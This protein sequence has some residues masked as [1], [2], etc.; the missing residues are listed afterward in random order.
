M[1]H[2]LGSARCLCSPANVGFPWRRG[3]GLR[4]GAHALQDPF[5]SRDPTIQE[6]IAWI[7]SPLPEG[8]AF[9][10]FNCGVPRLVAA[11]GLGGK[12]AGRA[13]LHPSGRMQEQGRD[14]DRVQAASRPSSCRSPWR[15]W[16]R[17]GLPCP[18]GSLPLVTTCSSGGENWGFSQHQSSF[19]PSPTNPL[20]SCS[21]VRFTP[22][23]R[24]SPWDSWPPPERC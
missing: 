16:G 17:A 21:M 9:C 12:A 2:Q 24:I 14:D 3:L 20:F 6:E 1:S 13:G 5:A 19:L 11:R 4:Y 15:I 7:S 8:F 22:S 18:P 10:K 23:L